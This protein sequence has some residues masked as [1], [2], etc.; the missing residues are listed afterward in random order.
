MIFAHI[1]FIRLPLGPASFLELGEVLILVITIG[2][3][4]SPRLGHASVEL[5]V[6]SISQTHLLVIG[7]SFAL[8]RQRFVCFLDL[9]EFRPGTVIRIQIGM[10]LLGQLKVLRFDLLFR[11]RRLYA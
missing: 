3:S 6:T 2:S 4:S 7:I 9:L 1:F 8:I 11:T 5:L 10:V